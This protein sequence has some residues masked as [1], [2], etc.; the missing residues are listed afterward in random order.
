MPWD[1]AA[2]DQYKRVDNDM[3]CDVTDAEWEVSKTFL[4]TQGSMGRPRKTGLREVFQAIQSMLATGCQWR[5]IPSCYPPFS[6]VQNY[7]Y[8]WSQSGVLTDLM[9][10]LR[11]QARRLADRSEEPRAAIS[12]S[13]SV[14]TT[15]SGGPRRYDAG[16]KIKGRK[17]HI[18]TDTTGAPLAIVIHPADVQDRDGA[19]D[20]ILQ[21]VASSPAMTK[22][23]AD[24]GYRGPKRASK[25]H[26]LAIRPDLSIVLKPKDGKGFQVLFQRW[27]V[28]R[29]FAWMGRCRRLAKDYEGSLASSLAWTTLAAC[30]FLMRRIARDN[31]GM[32]LKCKAM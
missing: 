13:P 7:F 25:L 4:P 31:G 16:Q 32:G 21:V 23:W 9:N 3:Q 20:L 8:N 5:A 26:E 22:I 10:D 17:R 19:V 24:G 6:T 18:M 28:E 14:K 15:E 1:K 11:T 27:I 12:D 2:R 30:R 29:T